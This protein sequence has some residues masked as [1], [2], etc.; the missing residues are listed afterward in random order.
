MQYAAAVLDAMSARVAVLSAAGIV[1]AVNQ[2]WRSAA[3][4]G[5]Y[6]H[7]AAGVGID[8][9]AVCRSALAAGDAHVEG[10]ADGIR[11]VLSGSASRYEHEY[12]CHEP[13]G[14]QHWFTMRASACHFRDAAAIVVHEEITSRVIAE[15]R[16]KLLEERNRAILSSAL[17]AII[18]VDRDDRIA[19]ANPAATILLESLDEPITG[20][21]IADYLPELA[22]G[23]DEDFEPVHVSTVRTRSGREIPVEVTVGSSGTN[24]MILVV[25]DIGERIDA[26]RE[27]AENIERWQL[28][29][30]AAGQG[31]WSWDLASGAVYCSEHCSALLG[32]AER[33]LPSTLRGWLPLLHPSDRRTIRTL[34]ADHLAG[35]TAFIDA[36]A[37]VRH[38]DGGWRWIRFCGQSTQTARRPMLW[39]VLS[40]TT[41]RH[42][43]A[44]RAR[45]DAERM[46]RAE[47]LATLGT[48]VSGVAHEINNPTTFIALHAPILKRIWDDARPLIERG[49]EATPLLG[50]FPF[51]TALAV[52][53]KTHVAIAAGVQRIKDIV[54]DLRYFATTESEPDQRPFSLRESLIAAVAMCAPLAQRQGVA[55]SSGPLVEANIHG[56]RRRIEQALINVIT[57]AYQACRPGGA[58]SVTS[59]V[60]DG[61]AEITVT[62]DG[63]GISE[64]D[65]RRLG[66]PFFTTKRDT[67][68][69]G[70]GL[71]ITQSAVKEHHGTF[72]IRSDPGV[73]TLVQIHLPVVGQP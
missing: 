22:S 57:N 55:I 65:L 56:S 69:T 13:D 48:L 71:S 63:V 16:L 62:D 39:G 18:L 17:D 59:S 4:H 25:R 36:E 9:L 44:E 52:A 38:G 61:M 45:G 3:R 24:Q 64:A 43:A 51:E 49:R 35:R 8:Y 28:A 33:P 41:E 73:G 30:K 29:V 54:H 42:E 21:R 47:R 31:I 67:G 40:D 5:G 6:L 19:Y 26:Q 70:L 7:P 23:S 14:T 60:R 2:A 66:E 72:T 68:G 58:V 53:E 27:I 15:D 50:G 37:R 20:R 12:P 46:Q 32:A 10:V 1:V 34:V 11:A